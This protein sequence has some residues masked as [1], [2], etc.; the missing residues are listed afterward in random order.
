MTSECFGCSFFVQVS[1]T[2][3]I[4]GHKLG[5]WDCLLHSQLTGA[6]VALPFEVLGRRD[7]GEPSQRLT[8]Y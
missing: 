4:A 2:G 5:K 3:Y 6:P 8:R 7:T 1:L